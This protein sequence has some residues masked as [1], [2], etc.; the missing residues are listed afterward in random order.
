MAMLA[1][2]EVSV[3]LPVHNGTAFLDDALHS[4]ASQTLTDFEVIAVDD[5]STDG[6]RERLEAARREFAWLS[7][8][9][10][11]HGGGSR[12]RN[13]AWAKSRGRFIARMDA[14]DLAAPDRLETQAAFLRGAPAVGVCGSWFRTFGP[15][16]GGV[17]KV[18]VSD[19][20]IRARLV[21]GSAFAHPAVMIRR[22]LLASSTGAYEPAE[23]GVEDYGLWLRLA[24]RTAFHNL[25]RVLLHYRQHAAQVTRQAP[26]SRSVRLQ[27]LR[28]D[29]LARLGMK[30][31]A[32]ESEAHALTGFEF[33]EGPASS[34]ADVHAWLG[35]LTTELPR[36]GWCDAAALRRECSEAW[37]RFCRHSGRGRDAALTFWRSPLVP[38]DG[39]SAWRALR[40]ALG[41]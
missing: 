11:E 18:P 12:A 29:L 8:V 14:D 20:A 24:S 5:G 13:R 37:W 28:L 9:A 6:S 19:A 7:V 30:V 10:Q 35:R 36:S 4:L 2:P 39:R 27:R 23:D 3:L 26:G 15:S 21:F 16:G 38:R 1:E 40:L 31:N 25:P 17:V 22:E 32:A 34:P 41:R 33:P